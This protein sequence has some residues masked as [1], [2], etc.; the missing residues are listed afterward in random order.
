MYDNLLCVRYNYPAGSAE[1]IM[2]EDRAQIVC[3]TD[4]EMVEPT[5][6]ATP[7]SDTTMLPSQ[8]SSRLAGFRS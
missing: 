7:K 1:V 6:A 8:S 4:S 2:V 5:M 3:R